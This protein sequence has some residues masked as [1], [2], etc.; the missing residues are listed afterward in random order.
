MTLLEMG[1]AER[2]AADAVAVAD[3]R[4]SGAAVRPLGTPYGQAHGPGPARPS[5]MA[6]AMR[7]RQM[8]E[9]LLSHPPPVRPI[10][11]NP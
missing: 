6:E 9:M 1:G 8:R 4:A 5:A 11:P 2:I 3:G 7:E 10:R